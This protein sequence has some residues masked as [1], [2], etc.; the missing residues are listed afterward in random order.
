MCDATAASAAAPVFRRRRWPG[1]NTAG[2]ASSYPSAPTIVDQDPAGPL[3][4]TVT[5][6]ATVTGPARCRRVRDYH[7]DA[8]G[9]R[10]GRRTEIIRHM[11]EAPAQRPGRP[12]SS[13]P[14]TGRCGPSRSHF[15]LFEQWAEPLTVTPDIHGPSHHH[16]GR[17]RAFTV[18]V[19][20]T[21]TAVT[22]RQSARPRPAAAASSPSAAGTP[23]RQAAKTL[24]RPA[25]QHAAG[26]PAGGRPGPSPI[27]LSWRR[28]PDSAPPNPPPDSQTAYAGQCTRGAYMSVLLQIQSHPPPPPPPPLPPFPSPSSPRPAIP[29]PYHPATGGSWNSPTG[30]DGRPRPS[31][32][33]GR[34]LSAFQR[35]AG[36]PGRGPGRAGPGR[37]GIG[38]GGRRR[39][40][41]VPDRSCGGGVCARVLAWGRVGVSRKSGHQ[42]RRGAAR[43]WCC[44]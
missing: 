1:G 25:G 2:P 9:N 22:V 21:V 13:R 8:G 27:G 6:T 40:P 41:G 32:P 7:D 34:R 31:S 18:T 26:M 14:S 37:A 42:G 28:Q 30:R 4:G 33:A 3:P 38:R 17:L 12:G 35:P 43:R 24:L 10:R 29:T 19:T 16:R 44:E 11:I 15:K 39:G 36:G 23:A 5:A 20:T